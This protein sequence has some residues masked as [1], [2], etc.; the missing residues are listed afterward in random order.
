MSPLEILKGR[1][2]N[3][4]HIRVF[5]CTCFLHIK[6]HDKLDKNSVKTIFLGYSSEKKGYKCYDPKKFKVYFSRDVSFFEN[7]PYYQTNEQIHPPRQPIILPPT[8][9]VFLEELNGVQVMPDV[10]GNEP[11]PTPQNSEPPAIPSGGETESSGETTQAQ[12]ENY[13]TKIYTTN[14][15][16]YQVKGLCIPSGN[17]PNSRIYFLYKGLT[18][19][20]GLLG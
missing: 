2:I 13:L 16:F 3:L 14:S 1:K 6:R 5:S 15:T 4:D 8:N 10:P 9:F 20:P 17:V 12:E 18:R 7:K 11:T 19:I